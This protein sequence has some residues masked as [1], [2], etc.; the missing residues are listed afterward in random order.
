MCRGIKRAAEEGS[1]DWAEWAGKATQREGVWEPSYMCV[2]GSVGE[3][4]SGQW[5][6]VGG[7]QWSD[8]SSLCSGFASM[9]VSDGMPMA[10]ADLKAL[11]PGLLLSLCT[12]AVPSCSLL[13]PPL[14]LAPRKSCCRG[15][16]GV[17]YVERSSPMYSD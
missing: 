13:Q 5:L 17:G 16:V 7:V 12:S 6:G 3:D 9:D 10:L 8:A 2:W 15:G 4:G 11:A 1:P 14:F